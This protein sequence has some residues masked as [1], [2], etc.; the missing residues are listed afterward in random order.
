[1]K[2]R[3]LIEKGSFDPATL[4]VVF[5]AFDSAWSEIA[6]NYAPDQVEGARA[7]LAKLLLSVTTDGMTDAATLKR[8][9]LQLMATD[10]S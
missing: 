8:L 10:P 7:R 2:A 5:A 9:A 1:M 3:Q 6:T 4:R